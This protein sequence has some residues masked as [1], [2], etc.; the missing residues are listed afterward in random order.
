MMLRKGAVLSVVMLGVLASSGCGEVTATRLDAS[1]D[2][3]DAPTIT[4]TNI[5]SS[6]VGAYGVGAVITIELSTNVPVAVTGAPSVSLNSGGQASYTSGSGT[7]ALVFT[8]TVATGESATD[9]DVTGT[10]SLNGGALRDTMG[11][12]VTLVFPAAGAPG[13]LASNE[14]IVV[15]G[16]APAVL[17]LTSTATGRQRA[18]AVINITVTFSEVVVVTGTPTLSLNASGASA[19][20][21][22]GSSTTMLSFSYTVAPGQFSPDLDASS[23]G[24]LMSGTIRD[25]AGN[26]AVRTVPVGATA[27]SL[28]SNTAIVV[29]TGTYWDTSFTPAGVTFSNSDLSIASVSSSTVHVRSALGRS[30]GKYYW[31]IRATAGAASDNH[32]G[33]GIVTTAFPASASWVGSA[34]ASLG[35]GYGPSNT[36]WYFTWAGASVSGVPPAGS[37][38]NANT[39]FMFAVDLDADYLWTGHDGTW[40]NGGNPSGGTSPVATGISGTVHAAVTFYASSANAFTANFGGAAFMYTVPT[41]FNP[42][43]Y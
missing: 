39:T 11:R 35:F 6:A 12:D 1:I 3:P 13:S 32:G 31:E 24:A 10:V 4:V 15:D 18:G 26:D 16:I 27:G 2:A 28:A 20:Y 19:T 37:A 22:T 33:L 14:E 30:S 21:N 5:M 29:D 38:V 23:T 9:L 36:E 25:E 43:L 7:S 17:G 40:H 41:G 8:Y 42:G 34:E